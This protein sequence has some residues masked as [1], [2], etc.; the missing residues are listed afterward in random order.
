VNT[1]VSARASARLST[2]RIVVVGLAAVVGFVL[3]LGNAQQAGAAEPP[4]GLG[5]ADSFAVLA[6]TTVTNTLATTIQGDVGV[7]P[8]SAVTGFPPGIVTDGTIHSADAVATQA[9]ADLTIAY[10]DAAG[11]SVSSPTSYTDL[12]GLTLAPG[13]YAGGAL[14]LTGT[15]TLAGDAS[16]VF[17][18]QA[19]ST[20]ITSSAS[21]VLLTGGASACN[22][23]WQVGSSATLGTATDFVGTVMALTSITADSG[24]TIDG[25]LLARNGAVTLD[26]NV[27]THPASCTDTG[28]GGSTTTPPAGGGGSTTTPPAGGGTTPPGGGGSTT[29]PGGGGTTPPGGG[30]GGGTTPPAGGGT[31]PG[32]GGTSPGGAGTSPGGGNTTSSLGG[33]GTNSGGGGTTPIHGTNASGNETAAGQSLAETG[34]SPAMYVA[35][36]L[37]LVLSGT[38]LLVARRSRARTAPRR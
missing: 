29:P 16:S 3:I 33:A 35:G 31:T 7:S 18:F 9:Q 13:V 38:L 5:T 12:A 27:I 17:I 1:H 20:L 2:T 15:V 11:R 8:G 34:S 4:V 19:A 14:G 21:H 36:G 25:R 37:C 28:G 22:V 6:G 10:D 30:A 24:A 32:G 23:F 26:S